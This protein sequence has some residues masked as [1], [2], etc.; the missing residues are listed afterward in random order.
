MKA[1]DA[2]DTADMVMGI[3]RPF[4]TNVTVAGSLR[5]H[6]EDIGDVDIVAIPTDMVGL[7]TALNNS[8]D[9][10]T[11]GAKVKSFLDYKGV[12][13]DLYLAE[14]AEFE[15]TLMH[16]T[17]SKWHNIAIAKRATAM[18]YHLSTSKGILGGSGQVV[19]STEKEIFRV[20]GLT[21]KE[22]W[23]RE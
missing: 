13:V 18:G 23:E 12:H 4:C 11:N 17:G 1:E 9:L 16:R 14:Q 2:Q 8:Y 5:R 7:Q 3:I 22:P 10:I 20:L 19:A 6:K 21:Y 15:P